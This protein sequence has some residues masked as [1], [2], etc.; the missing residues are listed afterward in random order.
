VV[1]VGDNM[2]MM[3]KMMMDVTDWLMAVAVVVV[4]VE[5]LIGLWVFVS[6]DI[7]SFVCRDNDNDLRLVSSFNSK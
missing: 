3:M 5:L 6:Q 7:S 1:S 4:V 2:T